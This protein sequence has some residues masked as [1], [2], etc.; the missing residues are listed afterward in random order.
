MNRRRFLMGL[1]GA[2]VS[3]VWA[4]VAGR[5]TAMAPNVVIPLGSR[6]RALVRQQGFSLHD[7]AGSVYST[8]LLGCLGGRTGLDDARRYKCVDTDL[9]PAIAVVLM[10]M[11]FE[12]KR[13]Y[14]TATA[15]VDELRAGD[16]QVEIVEVPLS[17]E[18]TLEEARRV[19]ERALTSRANAI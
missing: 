14:D 6:A 3:L 12:G 4:Q 8:L 7:G 16:V 15:T 18:M 11:S 13:R 1:F 10:P 19:R 17:P 2:M 5:Q 9:S